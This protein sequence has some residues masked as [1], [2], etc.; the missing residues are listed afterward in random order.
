MNS[1]VGHSAALEGPALTHRGPLVLIEFLN[2][3]EPPR[4]VAGTKNF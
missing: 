1:F 3:K 2:D 4:F